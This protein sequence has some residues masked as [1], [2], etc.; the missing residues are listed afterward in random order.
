MKLR[1][2]ISGALYG[3]ALGDA[4]GMPSELWGSQRLR[5]FFGGEITEFLDGPKENE[6]AVNYKKGQFT[7]DTAQALVILDSLEATKYIPDAKDIAKRMLEWAKKEN[8]FEN[9][10][11][12]PTSSVALANF[13][14]GVSA[15][16]ITD[17]ALSNGSSMRIPPIGCFFNPN[18]KIELVHY[19]YE[20]SKATHSSDVTIAGASMIAEGVA[21][22]IVNDNFDTVLKDILSVEEYGYKKG[23]ETFSPRLFERVKIG[24][25]IAKEYKGNDD[26]FSK[27]IYDVVG[28]GVGIIESVPAAISIAYYTQNPNKSCLISANLGGDT[29]T[30]GAMSTAICGAFVGYSKIKPEYIE[31]LRRQNSDTDFDRYI[32]IIEKGRE[33]LGWKLL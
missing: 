9:N 32:D 22:A 27:K 26:A 10:I 28:S 12:G 16:K 24:I 14:D 30:I 23:S 31:I 7:D 20:V 4:M 6:V 5:D 8:A 1:D 3:M 13:R 21:S 18:Q 15:S 17:N 33:C 19:V 2:K 11:L 29:D 25:Q